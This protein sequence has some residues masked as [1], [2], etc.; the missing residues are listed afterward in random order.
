MDRQMRTDADAER[1]VTP[2]QQPP[3]AAV[4]ARD[5]GLRRI[6]RFNRWLVA[7]AI[8]LT[9]FFSAV[10][11]LVHPGSSGKAA[12]AV[13]TTTEAAPATTD[14]TQSSAP[15]PSAVDPSTSTDNSQPLPPQTAPQVDQTP[16]SP[17]VAASG[18]S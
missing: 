14:T 5:S 2:A 7:G 6:G 4:S 18:G 1:P 11:A 8:G 10:A 13:P 12:A 3:R 9:A 16:S 15:A 17:P